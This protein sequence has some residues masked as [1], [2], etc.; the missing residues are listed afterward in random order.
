MRAATRQGVWLAVIAL[1]V[2]F[3]FFQSNLDFDYVIPKRLAR[4]AAMVIGGVCIAWSSIVFQTLT[5]NRILTPAIM[6]YEAVYLLLQSVMILALGTQSLVLLGPNGNFLLSVLVMLAYSW[7]LHRW[8][9]GHGRQNVYFLL[10]VG[11]VLTMV[12]GTFTQFVQLKTSPG[13]FSILLGFTQA[14]FGKAEPAQVAASAAVVAAV[15]LAARRQLPT[16]DVLSLGRD[17]AM[18]LGVDYPRAV[19]LHL[20]LIAVLVAV[21]TSLLGPTAFMGIFVANTAYALARTRRH[22]ITLPTGCA[23]AVGMF[24]LAQLAVEHIFNYKTTVGILVNLVCGGWFLA[25]MARTRGTA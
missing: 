14:S 22:R 12:I 25:L 6:G 18:S 24:I 2:A 11:L 19:Q 3:L 16:L 1:A 23:I 4:L 9:F 5:G 15:C 17:Q 8:L 7:L 20:A 21:S 13:E 10:L